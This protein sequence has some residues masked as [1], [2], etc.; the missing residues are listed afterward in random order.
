MT[1]PLT[2]AIAPE[3]AAP[4][5]GPSTSRD[6]DEARAVRSARRRSIG[7]LALKRL[8]QGVFVVWVAVTLTFIG[9]HLAPGNIIDTLLGQDRSDQTLRAKVIA[10]WG[11]DRPAFIQYLDYIGGVLHGNFGTSYVQNKP[12]LDIFTSQIGS[13][14]QLAGAA[15]FIAV[16]VS[17]GL[18]LW[19]SGK[20]GPVRAV[21][22]GLELGV[23][24]IPSFW[25]GLLLLT[26]FSFQLHWF[27][28]VGDDGLRAL[29]LPA[30]AIGIPQGAYLTQVLREDLDTELEQPYIVTARS[31]GASMGRVKAAHA[32]RHAALPAVTIGGLIVGGLLGG[33]AITEQVF[34]RP[35][36]GHIAVSAVESQDMPVILGVSF[37]AS[38]V[39][40]IASMVVDL[41]AVWLDPRMRQ[42]RS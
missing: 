27:P 16:L 17:L 9:I 24:S 15:L 23:L 32:L 41:V 36:L 6:S 25:L 11:L 3:A 2:P 28:V 31:R 22:S 14:L 37:F 42:A 40:V 5:A 39:F 26:V 13:T 21:F 12:V 35:G 10:E 19:L 30:L 34:G 38:A 18:S 33:A 8:L 20:H 7:L 4:A 1:A 29:V